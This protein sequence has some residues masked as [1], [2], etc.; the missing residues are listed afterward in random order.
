MFMQHKK[1]HLCVINIK[2]TG[3]I[4]SSGWF[5]LH[6]ALHEIEEKKER[7]LDGVIMS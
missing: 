6:Y 7:R 2:K 1:G 4:L 5:L 3:A